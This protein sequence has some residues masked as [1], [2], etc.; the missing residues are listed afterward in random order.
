MSYR[1]AADLCSV[2]RGNFALG[3]DVP[4]NR[5]LARPGSTLPD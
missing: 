4:V 2:R 1:L 3:F 5:I